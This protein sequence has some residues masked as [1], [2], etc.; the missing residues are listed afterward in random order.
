[1]AEKTQTKQAYQ[2]LRRRILILELVPGERLKEEDW[3]AKLQVS[4]TVIRE[5]LTQ[6]LGEGLVSN[7]ER[8]GFFVTQMEEKDIH[9]VRELREDR[10]STRLN[11][12]H[13]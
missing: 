8:G 1:M 13:T 7:G 5:A 9:E 2:E 6:L 11:S 3:A 4:R 12:S 10:K